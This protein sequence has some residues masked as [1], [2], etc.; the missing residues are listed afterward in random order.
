[1]TIHNTHIRSD[2][3]GVHIIPCHPLSHIAQIRAHR[4]G[5]DGLRGHGHDYARVAGVGRVAVRQRTGG[6]G[7]G[8]RRGQWCMRTSADPSTSIGS[9]VKVIPGTRV[10]GRSLAKWYT[11]GIVWNTVPIPCPQYCRTDEY[12][13]LRHTSSMAWPTALSFKPGPAAAMPAFRAS[14]VAAPTHA[15]K[16]AGTQIRVN[17][18]CSTKSHGLSID[19][20]L[21]MH[22]C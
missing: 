9:M 21:A 8:E 3:L 6:G 12:P 14:L 16:R 19:F 2:Q 1:M 11:K 5:G 17:Q 22:G 7:G 15:C 4:R 18:R 20:M 13:V 10:S